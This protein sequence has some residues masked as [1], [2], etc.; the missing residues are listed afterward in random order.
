[1]LLC[2]T[3]IFNCF[4]TE[5]D[6][7][8][9][10]LDDVNDILGVS[11]EQEDE[12][13]EIYIDESS[14]RS[15]DD[16]SDSVPGYEANQLA[17]LQEISNQLND[18]TS[19]NTFNVNS[20]QVTYFTTFLCK[21]PFK[22]YVITYDGNNDYSLYYGYKLGSTGTPSRIHYYRVNTGSYNYEYHI[23]FTENASMPNSNIFVNSMEGNIL[24]EVQ[25]AKFETITIIA[26][27]VALLLWFFS[28]VLFR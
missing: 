5:Y 3:L 15:I 27:C 1:M 9:E 26:F 18:I 19:Q 23:D 12:T 24:H 11:E 7:L 2:F 20:A 13:Q 14:S 22:D 10:L 8:T 17:V 4:A 16:N 28:R 25:T 21:A 6:S